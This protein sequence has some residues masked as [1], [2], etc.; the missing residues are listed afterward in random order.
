MRS[1]GSDIFTGAASVSQGLGPISAGEGTATGSLATWIGGAMER[2]I[3]NANGPIPLNGDSVFSDC[4]LAKV[5][6]IDLKRF[7][8]RVLF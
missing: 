6:S 5:S 1:F 2:L 7:A 4:D 8:L 3:Q